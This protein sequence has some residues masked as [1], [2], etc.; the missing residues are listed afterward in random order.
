MIQ[1]RLWCQTPFVPAYFTSPHTRNWWDYVNRAMYNTMSTRWELYWRLMANEDY[2]KV[3]A[4]RSF[5]RNNTRSK[6]KGQ[7][8]PA[9]RPLELISIDILGPLSKTVSRN[10]FIIVITDL[11]TKLTWAVPSLKTMVQHVGSL[12]FYYKIVQSRIFAIYSYTQWFTVCEQGF[13]TLC[14]IIWVSTS[15]SLHI[16]LK[17][18]AW[19][20][21]VKW[22]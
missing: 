22:S 17:V 9:S 7:V 19:Q 20:N 16:T 8:F 14:K 6:R 10:Q 1:Y 11:Y 5:T 18:M 4:C 3:H 21:A 13:Q 2:T 15:R 12:L